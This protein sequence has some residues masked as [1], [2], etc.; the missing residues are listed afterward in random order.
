MI[1]PS[2]DYHAPKT[3]PEA[4]A[5]LGQLGRRRQGAL[6]RAEP[7]A[8]AQAALRA[9][10]ATWWTSAASPASTTSRRRAASCRIGALVR[11][12]ALEA[13][14]A[15]ALEVPDPRRHRGGDRRSRSCATWRRWAATWPTAIRPTTTR[16]PC[17]RSAPRWWRPGPRARA[18]S[19]STQFFTG[20]FT[21]A[22]APNEIL[23][24]I[25]IPVPPA[26]SG[27]AYVK[28][29][30]KVGDFATAGVAAFLVLKGGVIERAGIGLTNVGPDADQGRRTPR[31]PSP[32]RSRTRPPS[33][34]RRAW[35]PRPPAPAAD[36]AGLGRLQE[37]DGAG[38]DRPGASRK[39]AQRAGG[40]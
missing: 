28:L 18:R 3:L 11:E 25:R 37:G 10:R 1:P 27:G 6:R 4:L 15:R 40:K 36:R 17:W 13:S 14:R 7:A 26:G 20:L 16:P 5:L 32:G 31:S 8:A 35:P 33:P 23:T 12:A 22:L 39:A 38:A 19:R 30:R 21:T 9:A 2:F 34:R 29:E 24:E